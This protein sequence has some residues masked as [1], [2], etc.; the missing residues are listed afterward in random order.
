MRLKTVLILSA[1]LI[2]IFGVGLFMDLDVDQDRAPIDRWSVVHLVVTAMMGFI[3]YIMLDRKKKV[4]L[5]WLIIGAMAITI[6]ELVEFNWYWT[7]GFF[8]ETVLNAVFDVIIG[9]VGLIAGGIFAKYIL[10]N[11]DKETKGKAKGAKK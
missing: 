11:R 4:K 1:I 10:S 5:L 8:Q 7:V 6:Y 3:F 2:I 9:I